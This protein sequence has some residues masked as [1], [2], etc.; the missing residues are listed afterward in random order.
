[1]GVFSLGDYNKDFLFPLQGIEYIPA[2]D[3]LVCSGGYPDSVI[4]DAILVWGLE[5]PVGSPGKAGFPSHFKLG[6]LGD[7]TVCKALDRKQ[8]YTR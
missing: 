1:M 6:M 3:K 8:T 2:L 4:D 5:D 7:V